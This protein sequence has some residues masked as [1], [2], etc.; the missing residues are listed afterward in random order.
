MTES[1]LQPFH[2]A[3]PVPDLEAARHFYES[4]LGCAVGRTDAR[5]IDFNFFGHQITAHLT[6]G[7][8]KPAA[9]NPVDDEQVPSRHFGIILDMNDWRQLAARLKEQNVDFLIE[10]TVRF[11]DRPGEQAT[12]FIRDPGGNALEFKAF[13]DAGRIFATD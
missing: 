9:T 11:R 4:V 5:W 1:A 6:E 12:L 10:P 7:E 2:L 13:A 3:F 8:I